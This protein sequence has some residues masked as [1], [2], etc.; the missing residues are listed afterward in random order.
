MTRAPFRRRTGHHAHIG[1]VG[2]TRT[3]VPSASPVPP[4]GTRVEASSRLPD[5]TRSSGKRAAWTSTEPGLDGLHDVRVMTGTMGPTG[6]GQTT[7]ES[8]SGR[9]SGMGEPIRRQRLG[10][11][12]IFARR[13]FPS[14]TSPFSLR[15]RGG[16][17]RPARAE[18][19]GRGDLDGHARVKIEQCAPVFHSGLCKDISGQVGQAELRGPRPGLLG[20]APRLVQP[21]QS[22]ARLGEVDL[23]RFT[24]QRWTP[25]VPGSQRPRAARRRRTSPGP[26]A[27]RRPV[28][29]R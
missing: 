2:P 12:S 5:S 21:H 14:A 26:R 20:L 16:P 6:S 4:I 3:S 13:F 27:T 9:Q 1:V 18:R 28:P 15:G 24:N 22:L 19:P 11:L 29:W 23:V 25:A 8:R 7:Q 10:Q 17:D